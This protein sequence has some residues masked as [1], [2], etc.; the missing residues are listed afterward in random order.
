VLELPVPIIADH[1]GGLRGAS[2]QLIGEPEGIKQRGYGSLLQLARRGKVIVKISGLYRA[3]NSGESGYADLAPIV[4]DLAS[5]VP[6]QLI[7]ASDWPHTGEGANRAAAGIESIEPFRAI[8]NPGILYNLRSW[9][10]NEESWIKM[11]VVNPDHIYSK[12]D[13]QASQ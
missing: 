4:K 7:W 10:G 12:D 2:K 9:V 6:D 8:D 3:S 13:D 5:E 1:I 11:L